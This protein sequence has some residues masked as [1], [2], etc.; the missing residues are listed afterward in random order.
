M[1]GAVVVSI[2]NGERYLQDFDQLCQRASSAMVG[3]GRKM[4]LC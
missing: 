4:C 1:V 3:V 2:L